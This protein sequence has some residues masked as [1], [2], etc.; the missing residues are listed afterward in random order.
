MVSMNKRIKKQ[1]DK[2]THPSLLHMINK[3]IMT[4][5]KKMSES[6]SI[7]KLL[8]TGLAFSEAG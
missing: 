4:I 5:Y 2:D 7:V 8:L 1:T 6:M 3:I